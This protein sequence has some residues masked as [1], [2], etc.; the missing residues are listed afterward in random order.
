[1]AEEKGFACIFAGFSLSRD[2]KG[3]LIQNQHQYL[4]KMTQPPMDA[5][6]L[7]FRSMWM[8]FG[9]L[10]HMHPDFLFQI[11]QLVQ[12][13]EETFTVSRNKALRLVNKVSKQWSCANRVD[14]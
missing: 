12:A 13:T 6:F 8:S 1:M 4:R 3:G 5:T 2:K 10:A 11:S 7:H 14:R 9:W